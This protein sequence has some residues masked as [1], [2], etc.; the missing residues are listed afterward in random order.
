MT[1][2]DRSCQDR[3]ANCD[4]NKSGNGKKKG[5]AQ[6]SPKGVV[7]MPK[8]A[9]LQLSSHLPA[10]DCISPNVT[11]FS[12]QKDQTFS[13]TLPVIKRKEMREE[14]TFTVPSKLSERTSATSLQ[15]HLSN[16]ASTDS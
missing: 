1:T 2:Q 7:D 13:V 10:L 4:R 15:M 11:V 12:S 8:D 16:I 14:Q 6:D 3:N 5:I 9:A